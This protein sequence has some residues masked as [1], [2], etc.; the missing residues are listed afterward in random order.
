MSRQALAHYGAIQRLPREVGEDLDDRGAP[1]VVVRWI[2]WGV[3]D[4]DR[5]A[6]Y[7]AASAEQVRTGRWPAE[8]EELRE[9]GRKREV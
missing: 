5:A 6:R 7:A 3:S 9:L 1:Q 4:E 2:A 8:V